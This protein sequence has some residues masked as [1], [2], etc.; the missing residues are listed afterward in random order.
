M[1]LAVA[2]FVLAN[3]LYLLLNRLADALDWEFFAVGET[4][5]PAFF[6]A[7]VLTHTGAGLLLA[8]L[9]AAF[10]LAHLPTV[11]KRKHRSS[12]VSGVLFV[13]VGGTLVVTGLFILSAAASEA[14]RWAWWAHVAAAALVP[15][16]YGLHRW[17]SYAGPSRGRLRRFAVAVAAVAVVLAGVHA[18]T[19]R[20]AQLTPE[21]RVARAAGLSTGPGARARDAADFHPGPFVP[22]GFVPP[23]SPYFP[24]PATTTSGSYLPSRILTRGETGVSAEAV[25]GEVAERGFVVEAAIGAETC[26][27]CHPDVVAQWKTSAHRFA[28]FNNPFYDATI[29]DMRET[30]NEPNT[31]VERHVAAFPGGS[32]GVGRVKSKWCSGCH[33]PAVML[34][35]GMGLPIDRSS[36]EAQAGLT[37]LAC[38]AIDAIHDVTGNANYN[39]ADEQ[40]DPYIFAD[41]PAGTPGAFLHDAAMRAKPTVHKRRMLQPFFRT[42]EF[43]ATCHKVS[44]REPVN[45]Y[46]WLR[47]QNEYDAWHDSGVPRNASRTFYLPPAART[48]QDCHMPPEPAPL[49]DVAADRGTV[50]SHRFLA[51][52][53][54]LPYLRGDTASIRRIEEFLQNEKLRV[55]VFALRRGG[56]DRGRDGGG[57][58]EL[59]MRLDEARPTLVPGERVTLEVV[60]RNVGVGHTFPGGTN[61]SNEGWLEVS[62]LD[63]A[64]ERVA[65]SGAIGEDG[66]LD[67]MAHAYKAVILDRNGGRIQKR[68]AQD[69]HVVAAVNVIGPGTADVGHYA[70]EVPASVAGGRL[71]V[72]ARLLW[73]KFDRAYTEFAFRTNPDGFRAFDDVPDLPVT[74]IAVDEV[75]L[76]VAGPGEAVVG[77]A[78]AGEAVAE[79]ASTEGAGEPAADGAAL[80]PTVPA[81]IRYNDYGIGLLL[82]GN[83]RL[84]RAAFERV[85]ELAPERIDGPLNL[86]RTALR[87]GDLERAYGHLSEVE[88]ID[89]GDARAAWVWGSVLREDGRYPEAAAAYRRVLEDFRDDRAAWRELGRTL[90]QD[91]RYDEAL[92]ALGGVLAIDPEDRIAHYYRMLSLRAQGREEE[93]RLAEAAFERFRIDESAQELTRAFRELNPGVNLMAQ[94]IHTHELGW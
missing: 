13:V 11:W 36:P 56:G 42:G 75:T 77:E 7:M 32:E 48:C 70:F 89:A 73:R 67:P 87:S 80:S 24:S 57:G 59:I 2:A 66:H 49:G 34:A 10:F 54:A 3:T 85:A 14:N 23:E 86:A 81:W 29:T 8:L 22:A 20:E 37:C 83:T 18:F 26:A 12:I 9:M 47:G 84:A 58:E 63:G 62:V 19:R 30:A 40:E 21:A 60:V 65:R 46:R 39:I 72:R 91:Q 53:T 17:V 55:D 61:D 90:Y 38:H 28:S 5:L 16:G 78:A 76:Q 50:R 27:R 88:E 44:L 45:N 71:T 64:G 41:A 43:C 94:P 33:D 25:A 82:E 69:I 79:G 1:A 31:W 4:T 6:Q 15:I 93:A 52:N 35:G 51:V 68:N 74:T 92:E